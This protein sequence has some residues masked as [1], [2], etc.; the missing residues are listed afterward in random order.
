M[1][2]MWCS[3]WLCWIISPKACR[4][5][6][7][8]S[9]SPALDP[10]G[11]P[12]S[13]GPRRCPWRYPALGELAGA[14]AVKTRGTGS[15]P[16]PAELFLLV[17]QS[18]ALRPQQLKRRRVEPRALE[19]VHR[20][21]GRCTEGRWRRRPSTL[22]GKPTRRM[23]ASTRCPASPRPDEEADEIVP[24]E[25]LLA[26]VPSRAAPRWRGRPRGA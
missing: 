19:L 23:V 13:P 16:R 3:G 4:A 25:L 18:D 14:C 11:S 2:R 24:E 12:G 7:I 10:D 1:M 15:A 22:A 8:R 9:R 20:A 26:R 17:H 5:L 21:G 6:N